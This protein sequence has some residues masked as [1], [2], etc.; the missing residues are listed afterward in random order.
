MQS[1]L[2]ER[3]DALIDSIF[4]NN[5]AGDSTD[6]T[7]APAD[8]D[9]LL[10]D[11]PAWEVGERTPIGVP[12]G[13]CGGQGADPRRRRDRLIGPDPGDQVGQIVG[14]LFLRPSETKSIARSAISSGVR[15]CFQM[16]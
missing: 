7:I 13:D 2:S 1:G 3:P 11:V 5:N 12:R 15:S 6:R 14:H 8:S 9:S 16:P 4:A 10:A